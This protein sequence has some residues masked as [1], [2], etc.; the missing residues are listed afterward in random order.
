LAQSVLL[1]SAGILSGFVSLLALNFFLIPRPFGDT[2]FRLILPESIF[3]SLWG[4]L[5]FLI[6]QRWKERKAK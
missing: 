6:L 4:F 1:F 3:T 2:L 5:F